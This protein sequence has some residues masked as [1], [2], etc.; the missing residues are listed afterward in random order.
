MDIYYDLK[1]PTA[2]VQAY[3]G[4]SHSY[5]TEDGQS[6]SSPF[7]SQMKN[8]TYEL[9]RTTTP[10]VEASWKTY[11]TSTF[12]VSTTGSSS[13]SWFGVELYETGTANKYSYRVVET[14]IN[15]TELTGENRVLGYAPKESNVLV[16]DG[17]GLTE[18]RTYYVTIQNEY[19]PVLQPVQDGAKASF[20]V[21]KLMPAAQLSA[22]PKPAALTAGS[23]LTG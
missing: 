3:K 17:N 20:T 19:E 10:E 6:I 23:R 7:Q 11:K 1:N 2:T 16:N 22:S 14:H 12:N 18:K 15:G 4:W 8:V 13:T 5:L 9:Q 21:V